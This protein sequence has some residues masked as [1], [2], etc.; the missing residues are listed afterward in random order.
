LKVD[1]R[2]TTASFGYP[3]TLAGRNQAISPAPQDFPSCDRS[4]ADAWKLPHEHANT[5]RDL[6]EKYHYG[7]AVMTK[8]HYRSNKL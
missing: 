7:Q 4:C 8:A 2:P 5:V 6:K 1:P 3:R